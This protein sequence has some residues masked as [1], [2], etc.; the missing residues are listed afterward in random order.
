MPTVIMRPG[1]V[2]QW[3][4]S[5]AIRIGT[6]VLEHAHLQL[7]DIVDVIAGEDEII[8]RR[9]RPRVTMAALLAHFDPEK[10]RHDIAFDVDPEGTETR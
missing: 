3:G 6:A 8:I 7:N 10:H 9:Q 4:N 1:K 2:A 5:A